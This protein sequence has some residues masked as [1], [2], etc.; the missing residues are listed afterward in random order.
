MGLFNSAAKEK[1][2]Q[3]AAKSNQELK[4]VSSVS[5]KSMN[6]D[7]NK[8]SKRVVEYF[9][10]SPAILITEKSELHKYVDKCI[11]FGYA[12][13]DTETTGLDRIHDWVVGA[14]LYVPGEPECYIPCKH[15]VPIFE[16]PY[17]NQMSYQDLALE[18]QRLVDNH[19]RLIF[20]NADFDLAMIYNSLKVDLVPAFYFDVISA[21]R[22]LKENEKDNS[23]KGLYAKYV[24]KGKVDPMK[25]SDF[26]PPSLFPFCKPEVAKLYA[27]NDAKITY[28]LFLWQLPYITT[29][30]E[31][32]KKNHLEKIAN[33]IWNVEFPMV[34]ACAHLHRRGIYLDDS[35]ASTLHERYTHSL[36]E[37]RLKLAQE[38]QALIDTK[39]IEINKSRPFRH[40]SDFN[41]NSQPHVKYLLNKLL[42]RDV[43]STG[44]DVLKEINQPA[45]KAILDVRGDVKLISTYVDKMPKAIAKDHRVH[46]SFKAL[47]ASTGRMC[48]AKGTLV[49]VLNGQK[50]I[51]DIVPG[52]L[53]YCYD[54]EGNLQLAPVKNLWKTGEDMQCVDIK[55]QSSG[56]GDIGHLI[57]TPEHNVLKKDGTWCAA[58][59]L[60]RY[61]K[62]AHLRR[63]PGRKS[64]PRPELYGWNG[65]QTREQDVV[66]R[67]IFKADSQLVIHHKDGNCSNN[68]LSNLEILTV[69]EHSKLHGRINSE[70]HS[71]KYAH[72]QEPE[73]IEK[74]KISYHNNYIA[75]VQSEHDLLIQ[76]IHEAKGILSKVPYDFD[77]FK[78]RCEVAGVDYVDECRKAGNIRFKYRKSNEIGEDE[79][80]DT[81]QR[82]KGDRHKV[83]SCLNISE[84]T[85][86]Q[87]CHEYN[88]CNNHMVQSVTYAGRFDVYDIEVE[89]YHNF[90]AGEIC[91]HNSSESPN[92]QNIP[93]KAHDIRH[94]F[95]ATPEQKEL[96]NLTDEINEEGALT[97]T[98]QSL[99]SVP[100]ESGLTK[101]KD[102]Q[103]GIHVILKNSGVDEL[104]TLTDIQTDVGQVTLSL[105]KGER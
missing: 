13:I 62:L 41:P 4:P 53:V 11:E 18:L 36:E 67:S 86:Y 102:L 32:C 51:E 98:L 81:Y 99:D 38:V 14:S 7:L 80:I 45:T 12:G 19:V 73:I 101:V 26:F 43:K 56:S 48:I 103:K 2:A 40:G 47:G 5:T 104:Y 59:D 9:K 63:T 54:E 35:I 89:T 60:K 82:F 79:F 61:D 69:A 31:K 33:L 44:K 77:S 55:W 29:T 1:I 8:I 16:T 64:E 72:L 65:I 27:A 10:D 39:D 52:D 22:C 50:L 34:F 91:V 100:T 96:L 97:I 87:K 74:R 42:G 24:K 93:S 75:R 88:L 78:K 92:L 90:I 68:D 84:H 37:D 57:C 25:F 28:E 15:I 20:A 76:A 71:I 58:S 30:H 83:T 105:K 70:Q 49:T 95:R 85:F 21:W 3:I 66:K 46:G 17:K 94:M 23:L 6:D